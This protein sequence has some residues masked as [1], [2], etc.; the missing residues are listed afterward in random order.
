MKI[1]IL[2]GGSGTR[3]WPLSRKHFPKQFLK[4]DFL[5]DQSLFQLTFKRALKISDAKNIFI[6]T[7][8]QQKIMITKQIE[9]LGIDGFDPLKNVLIEPESKNTMPAI[10]FAML[11]AHDKFLILPCDH[12]IEDEEPFIHAVKYAKDICENKI[13]TFGIIPRS[14]HTGYGYLREENGNVIEF[15]EKP[16]KE[17]ALLFI[18]KGFLWNS[19]IFMFD[20]KMLLKEFIKIN[21]QFEE[22]FELKNIEEIYQKLPNESIDFGL[23]EKSSMIANVPV[24]IKWSDLGSFD[25][26][27][28]LF[29]KDEN[30]NVKSNNVFC[31]NSF[32]NLVLNDNNK[33]IIQLCDINDLIVVD[34]CDALL[35]CKKQQS[36]KVKKIV[37]NFK[38]SDNDI[39]NF[40]KKIYEEWG[41]ST[42]LKEGNFF[43][44]KE[45]EIMP[46]KCIINCKNNVSGNK[47]LCIVQGNVVLNVNDKIIYA[48]TGEIV[49][50]NKS[51]TIGFIKNDY[52]ETVK[53][54]E[55]ITVK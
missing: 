23:L 25:S 48:K 28:E 42:I 45:I 18:Q 7:N 27:Y 6:I 14:A 22:I 49:N 31:E 36:E 44:V 19:G 52:E 20:K 35:V 3:L 16:D 34:T 50:I 40:H 47:N 12:F 17:R 29:F 32:N 4:F 43:T 15:Y 8:V 46:F 30:L 26:I 2:V 13:V 24:D 37:G 39:I 11:N 54:I 21:P 33:K 1:F 55:T 53:I 5:N 51:D 38:Q 9:E 41:N 10:I